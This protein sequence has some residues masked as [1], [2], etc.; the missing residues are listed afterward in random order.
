MHWGGYGRK[1][2]QS[3]NRR[4]YNKAQA[5]CFLAGLKRPSL[6][7]VIRQNEAYFSESNVKWKIE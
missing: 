1:P 2:T 4:E 3:R 7:R 6:G 5:L